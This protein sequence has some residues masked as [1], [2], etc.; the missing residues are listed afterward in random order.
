MQI[1]RTRTEVERMKE[2]VRNLKSILAS[3]RDSR[4][5]QSLQTQIRNLEYEIRNGR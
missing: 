3:C 4:Q 1:N 2:E 5:R